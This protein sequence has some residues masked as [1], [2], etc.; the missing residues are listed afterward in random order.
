MTAL[1]ERYRA[2]R[3]ENTT[4]LSRALSFASPPCFQQPQEEMRGGDANVSDVTFVFR[5]ITLTDVN[6]F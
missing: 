2:K 3:H 6:R 5:H 4:Q 1:R